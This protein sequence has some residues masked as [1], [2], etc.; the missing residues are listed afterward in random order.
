[1]EFG[2]LGALGV[3]AQEHVALDLRSGREH[4][5]HLQET[6]ITLALLMDTHL[7]LKVVSWRAVEVLTAS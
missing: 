6:E 4:A 5:R 7:T 3:V 2:L 1:M